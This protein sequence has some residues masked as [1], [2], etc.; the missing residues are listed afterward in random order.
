MTSI[1]SAMAGAMSIQK[2]PKAAPKTA[3]DA[4]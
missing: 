1:T 3:I 4:T 2:P